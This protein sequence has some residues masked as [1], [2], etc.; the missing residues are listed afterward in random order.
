MVSPSRS[1]SSV[2]S[3]EDV[4]KALL[5]G[6][7]LLGVVASALLVL[8]DSVQL[9]RV[10]LVVA[11]WAA[12]LAAWAVSRYQNKI[13]DLRGAYERELEREI[14]A[15][16]EHD[17]GLEA[18]VRSEV[19]ADAAE[20][21]ALRAE[22][23]V[24]R[25]QLERLFDGDLP[26]ERPAL[27]AAFRVQELPS[28]QD[29]AGFA[30]AWPL[31]EDGERRAV[32]AWANAAASWSH[33]ADGW[34]D[35]GAE[36][37]DAD[38][39]GGER[40]T[41]TPV[42]E[43]DHPG[44]PRFAG[45]D[46]DPITAETAIVR[47]DDE[48]GQTGPGP[49]LSVPGWADAFTEVHDEPDTPGDTEHHGPPHPAEFVQ[50]PPRPSGLVHGAPAAAAWLGRPGATETEPPRAPARGEVREYARVPAELPSRS[51]NS[52]RRRAQADPAGSR[53]LSVAEIMANLRREEEQRSS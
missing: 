41:V 1:S 22:L 52:R 36:A 16:R 3:R 26:P 40:S 28:A 42:Y 46:D 44:R 18:R 13:R 17:L 53:K 24:L 47:L 21:A 34:V 32:D 49:E 37:A 33:A 5:G 39:D 48:P 15:R 6:L 19:G 10:G 8:S 29:R 51:V 50:G 45:P 20:M 43:S 4:G 23:A 38:A 31:P 30:A 7:V 27:R 9:I 11:L 12:V 35:T 2:R 25:R 14:G